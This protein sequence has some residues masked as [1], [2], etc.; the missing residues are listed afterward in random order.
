MWQTHP[1][2]RDAA[3]P[4]LSHR[5]SLKDVNIPLKEYICGVQHVPWGG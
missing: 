4:I 2:Y 3:Q 5:G 1:P